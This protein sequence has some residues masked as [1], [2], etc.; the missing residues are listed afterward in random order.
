MPECQRTVIVREDGVTEPTLLSNCPL[1]S[2]QVVAIRADF[3]AVANA[4][5]RWL[6]LLDSST[7]SSWTFPVQCW[8]PGYGN[9]LDESDR[10]RAGIADVGVKVMW[11]CQEGSRSC[12]KSTRTAP[13]VARRNSFGTIGVGIGRVLLLAEVEKVL[14]VG[15]DTP[16]E[17]QLGR[18]TSRLLGLLLETD[19]EETELQGA[20]RTCRTILDVARSARLW[21][22]PARAN[23][24][25]SGPDDL[26]QG[27]Y[28]AGARYSR[29]AQ[30]R[31]MALKIG[32]LPSESSSSSSIPES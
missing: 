27:E 22:E 2:C 12:D 25:C 7:T 23:V 20:G 3:G 18:C 14:R 30:K 19:G 16:T 11:C 10:Q 1:D 28:A 29:T 9:H 5:G 15:E 21:G 31:R 13:A 26:W 17:G 32:V 6:R 24:D 4:G 8:E